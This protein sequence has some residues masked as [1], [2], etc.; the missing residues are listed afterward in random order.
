[1]LWTLRPQ[2][3]DHSQRNVATPEP[4]KYCMFQFFIF[5]WQSDTKKTL[6]S[7]CWVSIRQTDNRST[8]STGHAS[9]CVV[10]DG[11]MH[12]SSQLWTGCIH[13]LELTVYLDALAGMWLACCISWL[14]SNS[15]GGPAFIMPTARFRT[16]NVFGYVLVDRTTHFRMALSCDHLKDIRNDQAVLSHLDMPHL[17]GEWTIQIVF[18]KRAASSTKQHSLNK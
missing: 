18:H 15:S 8:P 2:G 16:C 10:Q 14:M 13:I 1:M 12:Y 9:A 5:H 3:G 7:K 4:V 11:L 17:K 6:I